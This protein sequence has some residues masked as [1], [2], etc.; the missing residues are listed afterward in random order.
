MAPILTILVGIP[1]SGKSSFVEPFKQRHGAAVVLSSDEVRGIL[2]KD[3]SD[4]SVSRQ[5]FQF[6]ECAAELLLR[7]GRNVVID[8][9]NTTAKARKP[10]VD[11]G[12]KYGARIECIV[13][14]TSI[15]NCKKRNA[16]RKRQVPES[17]IDRM[18]A[19]LQVPKVFTMEWQGTGQDRKEVI[20]DGECHFVEIV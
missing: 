19:Q 6:L 10:F 17:V 11:L 1:G 18:A 4:Q 7:Q 12:V 15:E 2:G 5:T 9:T 3:E 16:E 13:V 8:A 14:N 20:V